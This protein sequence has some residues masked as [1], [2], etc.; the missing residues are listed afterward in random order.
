MNKILS[1]LVF[2]ILLATSTQAGTLS[3]GLQSMLADKNADETVSV[4]VHMME[5]APIKELQLDMRASKATRQHRHNVVVSALQEVTRAQDD[6]LMDL[7]ERQRAGAVESYTSYWISNLIV[8]DATVAEIERIADRSDVDMVEPNY[9]VELIEPLNRR[10]VASGG[11]HEKDTQGIGITNGLTAINADRVWYELGITGEGRL[12]G[13]LDTGVDGN[14]PALASSYRG[15][16][17]TWQESWHDVIGTVSTFPNDA[18][19]HGTHT[20]GTMAGVA[21][22]DTVGVAWGSQ[23]IAANAIDQGVGGA[24]TGDIINCLQWFADPDGDPGTVTDVPDAVCNSW[25]ISEAFGYPDCYSYW[26]NVIDN[27]EAAGCVTVWATGNEGPSASTVRSPADRATTTTSAF[28]VGSVNANGSYPYTISSFSSRGPSTCTAPAENLIK[29]EVSAPGSGVYSSIPGGG[30]SYFDGTSM[31]TPHVAGVVALMRQAAPNIEVDVI[32]Q[33]L[34]DS[35][36]DFGTVGEDNSYGW[37]FIDAYEAVVL[38]MQYSFGQYTG[39]VT[40]GSYGGTPIVGAVVSL[41]DGDAAY[42]QLT[43]ADGDFAIYA[44]NGSYTVSVIAPGF[45]SEQSSVQMAHPNT[46]T[47]DFALVDNAGPVVFDVALPMVVSVVEPF[48]PISAQAYDHSSVVG[49]SLH[50]R[51]NGGSWSELAMTLTDG[52]YSAAIPGQ[53]ANATVDYYVSA[54]DGTDQV[55]TDPADA[56]LSYY[57]LVV[58]DE[59]Y[60]Y[61][62]ED[63][64]DNNWQMGIAGDTA[65]SGLWERGDPVE[66]SYAGV[67]YQPEDD[68]TPDPGIL[69][70]VTGNGEPGGSVT[71][72][73][74]DGGCTTLMS[75]VFDLTGAETAFA[76]YWRWYGEGGAVP[77]DE[78]AVD[79]SD[80]GGASWVVVERVVDVAAEW[81]QVV[82][83]LGQLIDFT[84][85]VIFR[86]VGCDLNS[87]SLV[88]AA[89]DDFSILAFTP[90]T[91]AVPEGTPRPA[92]VRLA[93]NHPNPFNPSTTIS[94]ELP[95]TGQVELAVYALDGRRITTLLSGE[96]AAGPHQVIWN[97]R[98]DRGQQVASGTYFYR[99]QAGVQELTRRMVLIK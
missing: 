16:T 73:D 56:P 22:D 36:H 82:V 30:Y 66:S 11:S 97:G 69:C 18:N 2:A 70:F 31:A 71:A 41:E 89:I 80:D 21:P 40:N 47:E 4:I 38:A 26:Y 5:Q 62:V 42:D 7:S 3:P 93:Q 79:V 95:Q 90:Q 60:A 88:D 34:M 23:W 12:V 57:T 96:M 49:A 99:L 51:A 17:H 6:L 75:P 61:Q 44:P 91:T 53:D 45:A 72:A 54:V 83:D 13:S 65:S 98:D 67:V 94:F 50:Y 10:D 14:H 55:G 87:L 81:T 78:F 15:L 25:G 24:F 68:H 29:P 64:V 20:T 1:P 32:K 74:I 39:R 76:K 19:S 33:I 77:D 48:Y 84:D 46:I 58:A 92:V 43:N 9:K 27:C 52:L 35:A 8:V 59:I 63:P 28:S 86:F 85:Q 37:G